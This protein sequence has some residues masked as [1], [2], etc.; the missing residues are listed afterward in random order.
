MNLSE[1]LLGFLS[2]AQRTARQKTG[3]RGSVLKL[4]NILFVPSNTPRC[5]YN[6]IEK[7]E[8]EYVDHLHL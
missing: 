1:K 7:H 8:S 6:G 4:F 2:I 5:N 3:G